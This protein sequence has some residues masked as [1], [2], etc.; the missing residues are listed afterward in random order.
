MSVVLSIWLQLYFLSVFFF[1]QK[2]AYEVRISDW[3]SDVCS[4]D[5]GDALE[6]WIDDC[7][8]DLYSALTFK[9]QSGEPGAW[10]ERLRFDLKGVSG[11]RAILD[12]H[13]DHD[14]HRLMTNLAGQD[15][16]AV[17]E[18]FHAVQDDAPR[19]FIA[20]TI[21]GFGTPLAGHKDNHAGLMTPRSEEHT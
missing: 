11:I 9:G 10:R 1:K 2:M 21:K 14:L 5:L 4:S 8:N 3:S 20:Y 13:D 15:M 16:E 7:P 18:A 6:K 12:Q 17:L 19:C